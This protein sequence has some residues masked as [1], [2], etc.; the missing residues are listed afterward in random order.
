MLALYWGGG[1]SPAHTGDLSSTGGVERGNEG[2]NGISNYE[3]SVIL[4]AIITS[5]EKWRA[6]ARFSG[7]VQR[8]KMNA[9]LERERIRDVTM[10]PKGRRRWQAP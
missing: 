7:N 2:G 8:T 4:D 3:L 10:R 5:R 9:G 6:F 1:L